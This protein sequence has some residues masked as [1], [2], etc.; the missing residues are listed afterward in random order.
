MALSS[1]SD[2]YDVFEILGKGTFGEVVKSWKRSTG[3]MVAIKILKNDSY[4]SRIIKNEL[5][6]L[7]TMSEHNFSSLY[8]FRVKV[9]DF[10]SASIFNEVRYVKEPYIQSRFYRAPEILLGLPFCEKLD[11]WSLGCV[12]AELHLGWPLYPGNNEYDQIRYICETQGMPRPEENDANTLPGTQAPPLPLC[13][14]QSPSAPPWARSPSNALFLFGSTGNQRS[15]NQPC[16][17]PGQTPGCPVRT[18]W[19]N[20]AWKEFPSRPCCTPPGTATS[21]SPTCNTLPATTRPGPSARKR[22]GAA[23]RWPTEAR[24]DTFL[25]IKYIDCSSLPSPTYLINAI[26]LLLSCTEP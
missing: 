7:Q 6:L 3:E 22:A 20:T 15:L 25:D 11:M 2:F 9:I 23:E 19:P 21:C 4:R 12:M 13:L 14:P 5:K 10:G 24:T 16:R 1:R 17:C 18:G 26:L 8:P